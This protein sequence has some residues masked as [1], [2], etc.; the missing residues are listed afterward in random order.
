MTNIV[1]DSH[2]IHQ[3]PDTNS[4][5]L[6]TFRDVISGTVQQ[7]LAF[8]VKWPF[9]N[10]RCLVN[11]VENVLGERFTW[12]KL[13]QQQKLSQI[14]AFRSQGHFTNTNYLLLLIINK[15]TWWLRNISRGRCFCLL[16]LNN[17]VHQEKLLI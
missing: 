1:V 10:Q 3:I 5:L 12:H 13:S 6:A 2:R 14:F 16:N 15:Q 9:C 11:W 7:I 17:Y 8:L 4:R